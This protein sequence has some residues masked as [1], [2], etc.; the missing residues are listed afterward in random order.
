VTYRPHLDGIRAIAV[1]AV[2]LYHAHVPGFSGGFVGVDVFFVISGYLITGMLLKELEDTGGISIRRFVERRIRRLAPALFVVL[3]AT[4]VGGLFWLSPIGGEQ[5]GLAKSAIAT[6][7]LVAN[8][9]FVL[10]SGN[11]FD[12]PPYS[13]PLL[14]TWSL[15]V[16][17][18]FYLVWPWLL[19]AAGMFAARR[20]LAPNR[21]VVWLM[22]IVAVV[23]FVACVVA[24]TLN[25]QAAFYLTPFRAWEFALGA[26]V[27]LLLRRSLPTS[28]ASTSIGLAGLAAITVAVGGFTEAMAFPGWLAALPVLGTCALIYGSEA[29][30][31]GLIAKGL[32]LRPMVWLGLLSYSLYLWHW[33]IFTFARSILL[34]DFELPLGAVLIVLSVLLAWATF[35]FVEQ[36]IRSRRWTLMASRQRVFGVGATLSA[37]IVLASVGEGAWAKLVWPGLPGNAQL[38]A[39]VA[40]IR[41]PE[42]G[43]EPEKVVRLAGVGLRGCLTDPRRPATIL[44]WGD[45]HAGHLKATL[46]A[47]AADR[48]ES[49][50]LYYRPSCPP[51]LEF[52]RLS[53]AREVAPC[54]DFNHEVMEDLRRQPQL[55]TVILSARWLGYLHD[56]TATELALALGRTVDALEREN[57]RVLIVASGAD[58]PYPVPACVIRRGEGRCDQSRAEAERR[59]ASAQELIRTVVRAHP[60][61]IV[62]DPMAQLC[63]R[64]RCPVS[65]HGKVLYSDGHH[66]SQLGA[67]ALTPAFLAADGEGSHVVG[68]AP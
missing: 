31:E 63:S 38:A 25:Q 33:P 15:S 58:F 42:W 44:L 26:L 40:A 46:A 17:E 60:N 57:R 59:R 53:P 68:V 62:V 10:H 21:V 4:L 34:Q 39:K 64:E 47:L 24:T 29:R 55:R 9:Y 1:L 56:H 13:L 49:G 37:L 65:R 20:R 11:Y 5:Q 18:Q 54:A 12:P 22:A 36:P 66:L 45:S 48:N 14:H 35:R 19:V 50:L 7:L 67:E 23:S 27:F 3:L 32:A 51:A 16:E 2:V 52:S 8:H 41:R 30:P 43:C 61:V 28:G 6:V